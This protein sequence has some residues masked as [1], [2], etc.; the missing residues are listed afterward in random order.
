MEAKVKQDARYKIYQLFSD[1]EFVKYEWRDV[2]EGLE[3]TARKES[4]LDVREEPEA[5]NSFAAPAT[6]VPVMEI[7]EP[8]VKAEKTSGRKA[9]RPRYNN[10]GG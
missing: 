3:D 1:C 7:P 9:G 10:A 5:V 6:E 2:P 4:L 8:P